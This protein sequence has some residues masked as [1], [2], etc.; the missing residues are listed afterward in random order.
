MDGHGQVVQSPP[1]ESNEHNLLKLPDLPQLPDE[2]TT[3]TPLISKSLDLRRL[4]A[5]KSCEW[6]GGRSSFIRHY[7]IAHMKGNHLHHKYPLRCQFCQRTFSYETSLARHIW[8]EHMTELPTDG[9]SL[10]NHS[11]KIQHL[12]PFSTPQCDSPETKGLHIDLDIKGLNISDIP[13]QDNRSSHSVE[14][15]ER[16]SPPS[17]TISKDTYERLSGFDMFDFSSYLSIKDE[18]LFPLC[19][20]DIH[21]AKAATQESSKDTS[22]QKNESQTEPSTTDAVPS[23]DRGPISQRLDA[24]I[25][26]TSL[27]DTFHHEWSPRTAPSTIP[28]LPSS[29]S[30]TMGIVSSRTLIL[31]LLASLQDQRE[32]LVEGTTLDESSFMSDIE[33]SLPPEDGSGSGETSNQA[34]SSGGFSSGRGKKRAHS[35]NNDHP[36][37]ENDDRPSRKKQDRER[38]A[39]GSD[40]TP[41]ESTLT[42]M[43]C[44]QCIS[45]HCRGTEE[46]ISE[47][48]R[49]LGDRHNINI[50]R[51]CL[52]RVEVP[53]G[54]AREA[55]LKED[56]HQITCSK[57]CAC[58]SKQSNPSGAISAHEYSQSNCISP[59]RGEITDNENTWRYLHALANPNEEPP[60]QIFIQSK[61]PGF[62]H[63]KSCRE[64]KKRQSRNQQ[65]ST[66]K[67]V[68][69]LDRNRNKLNQLL[70]DND[71]KEETI[72]RLETA[73]LEA[74]HTIEKLRRDCKD[75]DSL[76]H[77]L[78][79]N[80]KCWYELIMA[81]PSLLDRLST[82]CPGIM[83]KL[84]SYHNRFLQ[85]TVGNG[86]LD[87]E[88]VN[89][90]PVGTGLEGNGP[91]DSEPATPAAT[92]TTC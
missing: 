83:E 71:K 38:V 18:D 58:R 33:C 36:G 39:S 87:N 59:R 54:Q 81:P 21:F 40:T 31:E 7:R 13:E 19:L 73:E 16:M 6:L 50:C 86:L 91:M 51:E 35:A 77:T 14:H 89:K 42:L 78:L 22:I 76:I 62:L 32:D 68:E 4:C 30:S 52:S 84:F 45:E 69:E 10:S 79:E 57:R 26:H 48:L 46:T 11:E 37:K 17:G 72:R 34:T 75:K 47:L 63:D 12:Q 55:Y 90:M 9:K 23:T 24:T 53:N 66:I 88:P 67:E 74:N 70:A 15:R 2:T 43:R 85:D 49:S 25:N 20:D 56:D 28:N 27:S 5:V 65:T 3:S 29:T 60:E 82:N 64:R 92:N 44:T 8:N 41:A 80:E 61:G 1:F